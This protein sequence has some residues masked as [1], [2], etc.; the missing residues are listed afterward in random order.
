MYNLIKKYIPSARLVSDNREILIRCRYCNDSDN[1]N[2]AHMYISNNELLEY[3]CKK[4]G[5]S[6]R[7][8]K[9]K[10]ISWGIIDYEI[11][12]KIGNNQHTYTQSNKNY[13]VRHCP[14]L[15]FIDESLALKKVKYINK[16]LGIDITMDDIIENKIVLNLKDLLSI[17]NITSLTRKPNIVETLNENYLGF[18][19]YDNSS[20]NM[21]NIV[22][23]DYRYVNY[24]IFNDNIDSSGKFYII[25]TNIEI[26]KLTRVHIA[27]G[28]FDILGVKYNVVEYDPNY[29]DIFI[30]IRGISYQTV[31]SFI[32]QEVGIIYP[33]FH[34]YLDNGIKQYV[35]QNIINILKYIPCELY[36]FKNKFPNQKDF[37]VPK[38]LINVNVEK[39]F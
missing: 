32:L 30:A 23:D 1:P 11:L 8:T 38:S 6:G 4:C 16:R 28:P 25:P 3:H 12:K 29:N 7:I 24:T 39:I 37:G 31:I 10:L 15:S 33:I 18:L 19:S 36:F 26:N 34:I 13:F 21:R 9:S 35:T 20:I 17:N 2:H 22:S 5:A 14:N 27:E